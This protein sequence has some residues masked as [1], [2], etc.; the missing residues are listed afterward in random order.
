M[1]TSKESAAAYNVVTLD[2]KMASGVRLVV[3][4]PPE[5]E[6][7]VRAA[8]KK[9]SRQG[10]L[11]PQAIVLDALKVAAEQTYFWTP[12]W[13]AK[14]K[15]ANHAIAQGRV[16]MFDTMDEMIDFLDAQ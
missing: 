3:P 4:V 13:Q 8:L 10:G 11:S 15:A 2:A 12:E 6:K 1:P 5:Q 14:E 7:A 16:R 9:L